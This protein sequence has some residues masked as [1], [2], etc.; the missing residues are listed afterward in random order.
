MLL[1]EALEIFY[2]SMDGVAADT[3][4]KFYENRLP[5]LIKILGD[6][7]IT[8]VSLDDLRLWR[9]KLS[10]REV[11]YKGHKYHPEVEGKLSP[12]TVRQYV[13]CARRFF[14]WLEEDGKLEKNPAFHLKMPPK[15]DLPRKG[16]SK[17]DL[18]K[19]LIAAEESSIRD[20]AIV[21]FLADTG[22][23]VGGLANLKLENIDLQNHR[24]TVYEKGKGGNAKKRIVFYGDRTS[25]ALSS[26]I[27]QR[28]PDE[29]IH[30]DAVE[31]LLLSLIKKDGFYKKLSEEG[32]YRMLKRLAAK[33][34]IEKGFNPHNFRHGAIRGWLS[35][36]MPLSLASQLAGH[37]S[38]TVTAD[39]YG[40]AN[41]EE[42]YRAHK[43]YSWMESEL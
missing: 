23:R 18:S 7:E 28:P 16:I 13:K 26:L 2:M 17:P 5:S 27:L 20:L 11:K 21:L 40:T 30:Q 12:Y 43:N 15:P 4:I 22:C 31:F 41:E 19:I 6:R 35:N 37:S 42:L 33:W 8:N 29:E 34:G 36:G 25:Y 39:I 38:V 14:K 24:A 9:S 10:K 32:V 1:S 3:T